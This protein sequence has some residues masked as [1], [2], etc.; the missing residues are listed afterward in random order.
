VKEWVYRWYQWIKNIINK[1]NGILS[2]FICA[3]FGF[4]IPDCEIN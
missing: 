2:V 4:A 3:G 1:E